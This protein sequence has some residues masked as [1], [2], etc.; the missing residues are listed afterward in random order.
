MCNFVLSIL[1]SDIQGFVCGMN[2][3]KVWVTLPSILAGA[4]ALGSHL[5]THVLESNCTAHTEC[6]CIKMNCPEDLD[7]RTLRVR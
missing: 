4:A 3:Y 5:L 7:S 1:A 6:D 2:S